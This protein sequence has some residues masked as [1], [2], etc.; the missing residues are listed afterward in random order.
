MPRT[1]T[2][3]IQLTMVLVDVIA[4]VFDLRA[5]ASAGSVADELKHHAN[6]H[7][8][9]QNAARGGVEQQ[10]TSDDH[11]DAIKQTL[12]APGYASGLPAM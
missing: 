1:G 5:N 7:Y 4:W 12:G 3:P 6:F 8:V 10:E 2:A 9:V 11:I